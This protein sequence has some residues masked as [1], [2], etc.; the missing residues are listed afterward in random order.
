MKF[1]LC[2]VVREMIMGEN[3][4]RNITLCLANIKS[5]CGINN[6]QMTTLLH[7]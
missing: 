6:I 7:G 3:Y 4:E 1:S 5:T 2:T